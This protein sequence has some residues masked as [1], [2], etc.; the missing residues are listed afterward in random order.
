MVGGVN[1]YGR[2]TNLRTSRSR[3]EGQSPARPGRPR[4]DYPRSFAFSFSRWVYR[5]R[6]LIER[7]FNRIKQMRGIAT[8]YDRRADNFLA[9]I[10]LVAARLWINAL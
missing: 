4:A 7:F 9:A 10:K 8:R 1:R 2:T 5:Q 3:A 6:N